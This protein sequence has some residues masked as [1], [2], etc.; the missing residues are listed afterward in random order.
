M[1]RPI[2]IN[3]KCAVCGNESEQITLAST[4]TFG[5]PDLDLRP[6]EMKRSTMCWWI[7]ECPHCGYISESIDDETN[8]DKDFLQ[9]AEY[10]SCSGKTFAS[11][12]AQK[13]YKYYLINLLDENEE[14]A[15]YAVLHAAWACDDIKDIDN[16]V[17]C[18]KLAIVEIEKLINE[19]DN[20]TLLVQKADLLRRAGLFQSVI[21]EYS[22]NNFEKELLNQI[23]A[24]EI[25]KSVQEDMGC[26]TVADVTQIQPE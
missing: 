22:N 18:R 9:S 6:P 17:H 11:E 13:F 7:Q 23:I 12:L 24:F 25:E 26:Y 10:I 8:I 16:A 5:S 1:S 15:F 19:T 3:N 2:F 14:D 4:N 21:I 20:P